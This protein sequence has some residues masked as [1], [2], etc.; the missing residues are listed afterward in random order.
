MVR[1]APDGHPRWYRKDYSH[2]W[3]RVVEEDL[4]L[5]PSRVPHD[6]P[7]L[8]HLDPELTVETPCSNDQVNII[9]GHGDLVEEISIIDAIVASRHAGILVGWE[10]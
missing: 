6:P 4:V 1:V 9:N 10:I 2:H 8:Y 3:P 7:R 5:V